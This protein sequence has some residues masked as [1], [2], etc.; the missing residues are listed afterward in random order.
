MTGG[1]LRRL[2]NDPT[3]E[4]HCHD[5]LQY[6]VLDGLLYFQDPKSKC[7][8]YLLHLKLYAPTA[9]RGCLLQKYYHDHP[10][11]GHF[12][13]SGRRLFW[14]NLASDANPS[15]ALY[16]VC[17]VSKPSQRKP[18]GLMVPIHLQRLALKARMLTS[19]SLWTNG[20][21]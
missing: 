2:D 7:G 1:L 5:L 18:A 6:T 19:W 11:A 12:G 9:I 14:P 8:L 13:E 21:K 10:T 17:Q 15:V 3:T 16:A 20:L 4:A